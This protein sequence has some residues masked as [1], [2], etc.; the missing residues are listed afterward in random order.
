MN[1]PKR[2]HPILVTLHW[3]TVIFMLGASF[4]SEEGGDS[5]INLHMVFGAILLIIMVARLI[6]RFVTARP[7]PLDTG[8]PSFNKIGE[9][10]HIGLYAVTFAIL[11]MGGIIALNRNLFGY[12]MDN[13]AQVSQAVF[14]SDI[15]YFFYLLGMALVT[16]HVSAALYHE[17]TLNDNILSRMWYGK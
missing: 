13:T 12:L 9:L 17:F 16:L 4:L 3:L 2:Y 6:T 8:N 7:A 11:G 1:P 14:W 5:P 10:T 15:H